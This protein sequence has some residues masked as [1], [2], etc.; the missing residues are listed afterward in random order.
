MLF[1][2]DEIIRMAREAGCYQ[3]ED[4]YGTFMA[5]PE[6]SWETFAALV[7][8]AERERAWTEKDWDEAAEWIRQQE[9]EKAAN[10]CEE[11]DPVTY[12]FGHTRYDDAGATAYACAA[13]IRS[14]K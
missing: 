5:L 12:T 7:A 8:E 13:A 1:T 10:V 3:E 14:M 6:S 11:I 4:G 9:R 2:Q